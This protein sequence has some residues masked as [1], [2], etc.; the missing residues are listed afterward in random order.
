MEEY[1]KMCLQELGTEDA[2]SINL[3][4]DNWQGHVKTTTS[5]RVP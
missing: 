2:K 5:L 3:A 4:R 1:S